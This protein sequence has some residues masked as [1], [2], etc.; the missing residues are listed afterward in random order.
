MEAIF[1]GVLQ[2]T[3]KTGIDVEIYK[4]SFFSDT[5]SVKLY[6]MRRNLVLKKVGFKYTCL[7]YII[8]GRVSS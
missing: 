3:G 5:L 6:I 1:V 7:L 8:Y 4:S 2:K